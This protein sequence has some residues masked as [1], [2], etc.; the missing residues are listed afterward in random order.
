MLASSRV[1]LLNRPGLGRADVPVSAQF[2]GSSDVTAGWCNKAPRCTLN[3]LV[4][5]LFSQGAHTAQQE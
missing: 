2:L 5:T 1:G 4:G 3:T